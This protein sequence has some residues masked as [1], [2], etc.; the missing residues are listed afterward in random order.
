VPNNVAH[1]TLQLPMLASTQQAPPVVLQSKSRVTRGIGRP[2]FSFDTSMPCV[3]WRAAL[4]KTRL[5]TSL[6]LI[7]T[8]KMSLMQPEH[9][10]TTELDGDEDHTFRSI[11]TSAGYCN[12]P[13][14][15]FCEDHLTGVQSAERLHLVSLAQ[16]HL[17]A[18]NIALHQ[19]S[20]VHR[21]VEV[22]LL[23][24]SFV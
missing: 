20:G 13:V 17:Q 3:H 6:R 14:A 12:P 8:Y 5:S 23:A 21:L 15:A 19:S 11:V 1:P 16:F 24:L 4:E 7:P 22:D 9:Y 2:H 18:N 10:W